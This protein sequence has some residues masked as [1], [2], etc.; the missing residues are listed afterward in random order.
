MAYFKNAL[1]T[2]LGLLLRRPILGTCVIPILPDGTLVLVLRR[3]NNRWSLPGGIVDWGET[4]TTAA[5]REL[6]EEAGV[7]LVA[8]ERL[9]GLYSQVGRDPRFHSVCVAMAVRVQGT[10]YAADPKE[11]L[12]ARV[13]SVDALPWDNLSHDHGQHLQDY[14][15]GKT[16]LN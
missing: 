9:V 6:K 3:D 16:V 1:G 13:F 11:I 4:V 2:L 10:P 8:V 14:L 12:D 15:A 7:D 5:A